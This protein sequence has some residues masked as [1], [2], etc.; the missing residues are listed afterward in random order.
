MPSS[1]GSS[2]GFAIF[3]TRE[4]QGKE[5]ALCRVRPPARS[6][7]KLNPTRS[8]LGRRSHDSA[9]PS[10]RTCTHVC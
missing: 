7:V 4:R 9:D 2:G 8:L 6:A 5:W 10:T 1:G 3:L